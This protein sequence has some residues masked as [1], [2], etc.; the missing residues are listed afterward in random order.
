MMV[1]NDNDPL[2]IPTYVPTYVQIVHVEKG[3]I[4]KSIS[5]PSTTTMNAAVTPNGHFLITS[6][7]VHPDT[8]TT[9]K[10]YMTIWDLKKLLKVGR[11]WCD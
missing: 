1:R 4:I 10:I 11:C 8:I 3:E 9:G 2:H 6:D 5:D 7:Q